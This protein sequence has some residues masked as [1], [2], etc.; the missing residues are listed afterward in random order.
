MRVTGKT[1][2]SAISC[3]DRYAELPVL[4]SNCWCRQYMFFHQTALQLAVQ[5]VQLKLPLS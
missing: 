1:V 3:L 2:K 4:V 5:S